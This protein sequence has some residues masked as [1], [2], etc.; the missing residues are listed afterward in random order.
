MCLLPLLYVRLMVLSTIFP[1]S[2]SS[3]L[4]VLYVEPVQPNAELS[5]TSVKPSRPA[6]LAKART[7]AWSLDTRSETECAASKDVS[8]SA[9]RARVLAQSSRSMSVF[10]PHP[11]ARGGP[12]R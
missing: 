1:A 7:S 3:D 2:V 12:S 9:R 11:Q 5:S 10:M 6:R 8:G 4:R